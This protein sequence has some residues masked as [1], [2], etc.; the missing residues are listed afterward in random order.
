MFILDNFIDRYHADKIEQEFSSNKFPWYYLEQSLPLPAVTGFVNTSVFR[1]SFIVENKSNSDYVSLLTPFLEKITNV[2][3]S[4]I[5]VASITANFLIPN[6]D[7][8]GKHIIP[9]YDV[10]YENEVYNE[11]QTYTGLY[12]VNDSDGETILFNEKQDIKPV[13]SFTELGRVIPKKNR[14]VFWNSQHYHSAPAS[15]TRNR[16][17]INFN[18]IVKKGSVAESGLLQQS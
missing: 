18:F 13:L 1:H 15:A 6:Q 3:S 4:K 2:F 10:K 5:E 17:V 11:F 9:H 14:F 8:I 16:F 12:Y 7:L